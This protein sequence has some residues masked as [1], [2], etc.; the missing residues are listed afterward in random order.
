MVTAQGGK[1]VRKEWVNSCKSLVL[2]H[3]ADL[4]FFSYLYDVVRF[5][6]VYFPQKNSCTGEKPFD[7]VWLVTSRN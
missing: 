5:V 3:S 7:V 2:S 6:C 4:I 1:E